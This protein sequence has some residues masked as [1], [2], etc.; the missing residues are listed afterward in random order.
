MSPTEYLTKNAK[1]D[2]DISMPK[3]LEFNFFIDIKYNGIAVND[4]QRVCRC[5]K[6]NMLSSSDN[7][8]SRKFIGVFLRFEI[9]N[10]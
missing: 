7:G 2:N 4:S 6:K 10:H 1:K 3:N 5:T 9:K 8:E